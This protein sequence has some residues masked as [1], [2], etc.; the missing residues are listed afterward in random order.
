MGQTREAIDT[1]VSAAQRAIARGDH[2]ECEKLSDKA[3]KL[4]PHN[5]AALIVK[6]RSASAQGN[7]TAAAALLE[8][9]PNLEKGG[10]QT[11]LL[12]DLYLKNAKWEPAT[13][14]AMRVFEADEK[15]FGPTQKLI[16]AL[17][18]S[19]QGD[20]AMAILE[21]SRIPH[22]RCGRA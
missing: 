7:T 15:N 12:L 3:L 14:L 21:K 17:L 20:K 5:L 16:E 1:Y 2:A 6:A 9:V 8:Q 4:E 22:D 19:G 13:A 11:E 18:E 10:E